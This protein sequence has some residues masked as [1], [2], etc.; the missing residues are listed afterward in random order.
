M[1]ITFLT[2]C[3]L[4]LSGS[5]LGATCCNTPTVWT[6]K[7]MD[8]APVSLSC[9]LEKSAS[10]KGDKIEITTPTISAQGSHKHTWDAGWYADGMGMVPGKWSC[11]PKS[12]SSKE[13]VTALVFSTDWG[14][15]VTITWNKSKGSIARK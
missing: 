13:K 7:N 14:E 6:F 4:F 12:N 11:L 8:S 5:L 9:S 1:K 15:N 2:L 3:L 10:W